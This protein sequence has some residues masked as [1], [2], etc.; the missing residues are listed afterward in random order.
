[1]GLRI[2]RALW[3]DLHGDELKKFVL[4]G[5]GF[6]FLIGSYWPLKVLKDSVFLNTV[7]S[8]YQPKAK[9]LSLLVFFPLVLIYSKLIDHFS[10]EKMIYL[11]IAIYSV[12]GFIFVGL[13]L[14]PTIGLTNTVQSPTRLLGWTFFIFVESYISLLVSLYWAFIN[15]VT[16]PDSAKRGYAFLVFSTQFGGV[17]FTLL[18][19]FLSYRTDLYAT[20]VPLIAFI[21]VTMFSFIALIIFILTRTVKPEELQG[22]QDS[23]GNVEEDKGGVGLFEGLKMLFRCPYVAGIFG[24]VFFHEIVSAVMHYQLLFTVEQTYLHNQGLIN[25]FL[26]NFSLSIQVVSC[27]FALFGTSFFQ[28][29]F[30]IRGC[31][32]I[33]PIILGASIVIY[34]VH[35]TLGFIAG[36]MIIAKGINFVLNQPAKEA[37]YI[38][39]TRAIKYKAKAWIDMFGLRSAKGAGSGFNMYSTYL[40]GLSNKLTA[41]GLT[42]GISLIIIALWAILAYMLGTKHMH[43]IDSGERIGSER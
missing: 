4:L 31:L 29:R 18:G 1:M 2:V 43:V 37:L 17:L 24:T 14:H 42:G 23:F 21:S 6:F 41:S 15:D 11:L 27:L 7:G 33:Y 35:P 5:I 22:Y 20:R 8:A 16:T 3:G 28:R 39:T 13:F 38:P 9:L 30:G 25:K 36:V 26:F 32:V 10:K 34:M 12:L 19:V 40:V